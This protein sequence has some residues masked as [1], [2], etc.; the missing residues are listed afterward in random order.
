MLNPLLG[1]MS[2]SGAKARLSVL[3]FHRVHQEPDP[4]F[5]HEMQA[6]RFDEICGWLRTFCN[7]LPLDE[8]IKK[9]KAGTLPS[10]AAAVTFDDGYADNYRVAMPI[11]KRHQLPA[12]FFI[13]TSFLDGGCMWNDAVI[14]AIRLTPLA[15]LKLDD[16]LG[17]NFSETLVGSAGEKGEAIHAIISD[18]K[19]RPTSERSAC[20]A[21]IVLKAQ[22]VLP[23]N[24]MM[25][26]DEV[27]GMRQAGMQ[28]GAHT[29][30]HPI[31]A[32][33]DRAAA[34]RE[35]SESRRALE[36]IL[37][38]RVSL[39]AYPNGKPSVDYN[40]ESVEVVREL[41][42][43]AAFST[44]WSVATAA[45][46]VFQIPRF[47]PWDRTEFRFGARLLGNLLAERFS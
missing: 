45:T 44:H 23:T 2:P 41:G 14:E 1:L 12:T 40:A 33:L 25:T 34:S 36:N 38:D 17:P 15:A 31:L 22:V 10:R 32:T 4:L 35:I 3:I 30:S 42:F 27:R 46:D 29:V 8:A 19:Y 37:G 18:L 7:V 47:T 9:L 5:S 6:A 16:T 13:A 21:Q 43:D 26:S 11:L 20:V 24:L 28:I 39:F